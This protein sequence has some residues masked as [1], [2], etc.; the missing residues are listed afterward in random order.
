MA[1]IELVEFQ[2]EQGFDL[3]VK[4]IP[5]RSRPQGQNLNS[6]AIS[7]PAGPNACCHISRCFE[8]PQLLRQVLVE[9]AEK[10]SRRPLR[11]VPAAKPW[12]PC[13]SAKQSRK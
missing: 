9:G 12:R 1:K 8:H 2:D 5:G 13:K 11:C 4:R 10:H 6:I 3:L 7:F